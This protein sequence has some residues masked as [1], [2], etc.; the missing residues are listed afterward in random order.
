MEQKTQK[1]KPFK[2]AKVDWPADMPDDMLEEAITVS[3]KA[4]EEHDFESE[5][6][7]IAQIV[8]QHMDEKF[9]PY[10]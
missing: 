2:G 6:V 3:K 4:L 1:W 5:G 8:K 7:Q 10:W 9:Q